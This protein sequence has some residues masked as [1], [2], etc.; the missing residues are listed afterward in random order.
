MACAHGLT[1]ARAPAGFTR[2]NHLTSNVPGQRMAVSSRRSCLPR[3]P[4]ETQRPS[5][6]ISKHRTNGQFDGELTGAAMNGPRSFHGLV[7][8]FALLA[9]WQFVD[10]QPPRRKD[11]LAL[12]GGAQ[13][14]DVDA[15]SEC[16]DP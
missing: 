4:H 8:S 1:P 12:A 16:E 3:N 10:G 11:D 7:A 13:A 14:E 2:S 9:L 6:A 15:A 5:S